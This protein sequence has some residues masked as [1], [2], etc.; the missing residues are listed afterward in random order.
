[1]TPR[2]RWPNHAEWART[3]SLA[4]AKRGL[5]ALRPLINGESV[6][7]RDRRIGEAND[8]LLRIVI[9]LQAVGPREKQAPTTEE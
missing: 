2:N 6:A 5:N 4:Q 3:G 7:D 1:M 9:A 8:V